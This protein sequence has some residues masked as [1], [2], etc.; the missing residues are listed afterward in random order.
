MEPLGLDGLKMISDNGY[1]SLLAGLTRRTCKHRGLTTGGH[2][3]SVPSIL[4]GLW[5]VHICSQ[6]S[7]YD[8]G[9]E[10]LIFQILGLAL[11]SYTCSTSGA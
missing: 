6:D 1:S 5:C 4:S 11:D 3:V 9:S 8:M 2:S 10:K 7:W